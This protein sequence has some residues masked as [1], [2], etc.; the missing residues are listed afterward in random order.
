VAASVLTVAGPWAV[1]AVVALVVL[2]LGFIVVVVRS[3]KTNMSVRIGKI[4]EIRRG[5]ADPPI[6]RTRSNQLRSIDQP[7]PDDGPSKQVI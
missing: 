1:V 6:T 5:N 3:A 4:I 7:D 2:L